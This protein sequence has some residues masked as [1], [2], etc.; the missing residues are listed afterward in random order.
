MTANSASSTVPSA[1]P[2]AESQNRFADE[3]SPR[4]NASQPANSATRPDETVSNRRTPS[5][6]A[7]VN[8]PV[9]TAKCRPTVGASNRAGL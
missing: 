2:I 3:A 6:R 8:N 1:A 7:A 5:Y 9:T 4:S